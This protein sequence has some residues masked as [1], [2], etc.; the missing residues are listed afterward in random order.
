M[1]PAMV[2]SPS[3]ARSASNTLRR[4]LPMVM[5]IGWSMFLG[6]VRSSRLPQTCRIHSLQYSLHSASG[7]TPAMALHAC[8]LACSARPGAICKSRAGGIR[9]LSLQLQPHAP[10]TG[11]HSLLWLHAHS[12]R[13]PQKFDTSLAY[14]SA[15]ACCR[16]MARLLWGLSPPV[17]TSP[18]TNPTTVQSQHPLPIAHCPLPAARPACSP[19]PIV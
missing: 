1:Q 14:V 9:L 13:C 17:T 6:R 2:A 15:A 7:N 5:V 11:M 4:M 10:P 8:R 16:D 3:R 12:I 19:L 18:K